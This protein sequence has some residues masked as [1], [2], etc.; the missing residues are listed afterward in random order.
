VLLGQQISTTMNRLTVPS[1]AVL[2]AYAHYQHNALGTRPL[3][4]HAERLVD[5]YPALVE[6]SEWVCLASLAPRKNN[7]CS[8]LIKND[9][10]LPLAGRCGD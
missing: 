7:H 6:A 5:Q 4:T 8:E 10:A 2:Y 3:K 9:P 1:H